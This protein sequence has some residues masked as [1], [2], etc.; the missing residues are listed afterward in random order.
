MSIYPEL[1]VS[2]RIM[3]PL[4]AATIIGF[5]EFGIGIQGDHNYVP[6]C[7]V[8]IDN[9]GR[10]CAMLDEPDNWLFSKKGATPYFFRSQCGEL[11]EP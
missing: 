4:G 8:F 9:G 2:Q 11:T 1:R 10:V 5:E 7:L 3:T 6:S